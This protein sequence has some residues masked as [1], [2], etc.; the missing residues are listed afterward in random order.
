M[1]QHICFEC[2]EPIATMAD[3][4]VYVEDE[5]TEDV[6]WGPAHRIC[7]MRREAALNSLRA[8]EQGEHR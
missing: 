5:G 3:V 4:R 8:E 6:F 1:T 7:L 2:G